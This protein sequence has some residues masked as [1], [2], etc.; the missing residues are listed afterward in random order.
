MTLRGILTLL[1]KRT[2]DSLIEEEY[3]KS[4]MDVVDLDYDT[5]T[6]TFMIQI[7]REDFKF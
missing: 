3:F 5:W 7:N 2:I 6:L 1:S 4:K